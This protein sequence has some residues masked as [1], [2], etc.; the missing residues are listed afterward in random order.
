MR[1][2]ACNGCLE[3]SANFA[4]TRFGIVVFLR[5]VIA[6]NPICP[7]V[8]CH[9][10]FAEF[11]LDYEIIEVVLQGKFVTEAQTVVEQAETYY[12][13]PVVLFLVKRNRHLVIMVAYFAFLTPNRIPYRVLR[14]G[15]DGLHFESVIKGRLVHYVV[16]TGQII[17]T[18]CTLVR[19]EQQAEFAVQNH[20][21]ALVV[22]IV[23]RDSAVQN[24]ELH[25]KS[26]VG[27]IQIQGVC[28]GRTCQY[29]KRQKCFSHKIFIILVFKVD[30][31]KMRRM[32]D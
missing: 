21:F 5:I 10:K 19:F 16:F 2:V 20:R 30:V 3:Q 23:G 28:Q 12:H 13:V 32:R 27:R 26:A 1:Q 22:Q 29:R 4:Q 18:H 9:G 11:L 17:V 31:A 25:Y 7:M 24:L 8:A 15:R 14:R 6:G